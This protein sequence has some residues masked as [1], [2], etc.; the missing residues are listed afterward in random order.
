MTPK[1]TLTWNI[2]KEIISKK[3][4]TNTPLEKLTLFQP[5]QFELEIDNPEL[6]AEYLNNY[7]ATIGERTSLSIQSEDVDP[8]LL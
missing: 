7:F 2:L 4:K 6:I 3:P 5:D 1:T 8:F